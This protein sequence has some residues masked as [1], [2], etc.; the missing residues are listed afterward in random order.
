[1]PACSAL[2]V[3]LGWHPADQARHAQAAPQ[4]GEVHRSDDRNR[5]CSDRHK[6]TNCCAARQP[7][8]VGQTGPASMWLIRTALRRPYT[9]VVMAV[10]LGLGG[11]RAARTT[12]TDIF[13]PINI[14]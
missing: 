4:D 14:P 7:S 12:P 3:R 1:R 13:P 6:V 8:E 10:L 2:R 5:P 11:V 9:F